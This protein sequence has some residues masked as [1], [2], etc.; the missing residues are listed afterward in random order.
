[1]ASGGADTRSILSRI[2]VTAPV[3]SSTVSPRT[4]S[5]IKS[6][7]IC[8]GVASPDIMRSKPRAASSRVSEA[9]VA[10]LAMSALK[11]SV[12]VASLGRAAA[13]LAPRPPVGVGV[14]GHGQIEEILQNDMAVLGRD[15]FRM[16]LHAMHREGLVC[17]AHDQLVIGLGDS[18][19]LVRHGA[20]I[21]HQRMVAR[22]L[23]WAVDAAEYATA[24]VLDHRQLAM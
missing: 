23:E 16:E 10:A 17:E 19:Q 1:M 9:P 8:E 21:D 2:T 5:A 24:L 18:C 20:T 22:G 3:I 7:P 15:A 6:P 12:T 11:S 14:P 13:R 4:R